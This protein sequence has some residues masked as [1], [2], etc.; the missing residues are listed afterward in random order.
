MSEVPST[1]C[2]SARDLVENKFL[3]P[4]HQLLLL[5]E[6]AAFLSHE[7]EDEVD[8]EQDSL[9]SQATCNFDRPQAGTALVLTD[10]SLRSELPSVGRGAASAPPRRGLSPS[11]A[12][13]LSRISLGPGCRLSSVL[14]VLCFFTTPGNV[15]GRVGGLC[16]LRSWGRPRGGE[17]ASG[18]WAAGARAFCLRSELQPVQRRLTSHPT[19]E[20]EGQQAVGCLTGFYLGE[21]HQFRLSQ[22]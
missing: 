14:D 1:S 19:S 7:E 22:S 3:L 16:C 6:L 12:L 11:R 13:G 9:S 8:G 5:Q 15:G 20:G 2:C 21:K 10:G 18:H 17:V 4:K